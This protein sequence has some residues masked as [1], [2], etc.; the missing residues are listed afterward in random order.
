MLILQ[1]HYRS[2][3]IQQYLKYVIYVNYSKRYEQRETYTQFTHQQM[4]YLLTW[5]KVF[6]YIKI[7]NNIAPTCFGLQ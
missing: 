3:E 5:L 6:N 1:V 2:E 4:Q 7:H